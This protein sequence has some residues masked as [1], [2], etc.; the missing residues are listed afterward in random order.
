NLRPN[1]ATW[2]I[3]ELRNGRSVRIVDD[4]FGNVTLADDLAGALLCL[5][6][7]KKTGIYHAA[8]EGLMNR[9]EFALRIARVFGLDESLIRRTQSGAFRQPAPRPMKSGLKTEKLKKDTGYSLMDAEE[10]LRIL[11]EQMGAIRQGRP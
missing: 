5:Y 7:K 9:Y 2:L 4:Q 3:H 1:F 11:K 6:E 8:G 10:G